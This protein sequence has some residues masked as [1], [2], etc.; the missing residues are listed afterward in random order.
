LGNRAIED[1]G[2][3]MDVALILLGA[4]AGFLLAV[5]AEWAR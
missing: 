2:D 5:L 4:V 1:W 3:V